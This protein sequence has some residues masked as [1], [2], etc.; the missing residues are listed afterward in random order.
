[1]YATI[2]LGTPEQCSR[3]RYQA[4]GWIIQDLICSKG[5]RLFCSPKRLQ[6]LLGSTALS[7]GVMWPLCKADSSP[8]SSVE[9]R[10]EYNYTFHL[11][12]CLHSADRNNLTSY[13]TGSSI[14]HGSPFFQLFAP[15]QILMGKI[16][17]FTT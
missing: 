11:S 2:P 12:T 4:I 17:H 10:T 16:E 8:P 15:K 3:Y 6:W 13:T 1:M 9:V 5:K 14:N 7:L